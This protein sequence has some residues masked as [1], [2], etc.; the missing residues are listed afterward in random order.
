MEWLPPK[1]DEE[2]YAMAL[3]T[4]NIPDDLDRRV[5]S[6]LQAHGED[7]ASF[8]ARAFDEA[9]SIDEDPLLHAELIEKTGRGFEDADAGRVVDA[10]QAMREIAVDKSIKFK[11]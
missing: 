6:H 2:E 4:T 9:L 11:R 1:T 8:V 3:L 5:K 10:H 7:L